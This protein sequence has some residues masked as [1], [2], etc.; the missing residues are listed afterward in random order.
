MTQIYTSGKVAAQRNVDG[1]AHQRQ[2]DVAILQ[3]LLAEINNSDT[4]QITHDVAIAT[5]CKINAKNK[6]F[7]KYAVKRGWLVVANPEVA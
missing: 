1:A 3:A 5:I 4:K 7:L 2:G 6:A